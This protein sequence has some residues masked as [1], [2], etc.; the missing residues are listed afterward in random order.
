MTV[1]SR[2]LLKSFYKKLAVT[3]C[4]SLFAAGC[5]SPK[6]TP[7]VTSTNSQGYI[8]PYQ[9]NQACI[10]LIKEYEGVRLEAYRGPANHWLIGYGHKAGVVQGMT[11]SQQKAESML[12]ADL[13]DFEKN[14]NRLVTVK[15][16]RNQFSALVC[17][18]YN[19]GS[20]NFASS[21]LLRELNAKNLE[22][23]AEQFAVW[24]MVKGKVNS[25]QVKRRAAEREIF[26]R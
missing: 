12:K 16:N 1:I 15:L 17:L 14:V 10:D 13:L 18:A 5:A 19:I 22:E 3:L 21:T 26:E 11:I 7:V 20:G 24:R 6:K 4:I 2:K 23:A 25:H 9:T 8:N